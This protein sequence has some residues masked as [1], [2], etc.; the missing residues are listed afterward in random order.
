MMPFKGLIM[1][2]A[3]LV[4][5]FHSEVDLYMMFRHMYSRYWAKLN[6]F[7]SSD[8]DSIL[9]LCMQFQKLVQVW[10]PEVVFHLTRL[11]V[12]L[13]E[14]AFEWIH[15]AFAKYLRVQQLLHLWDRII[16]YDRCVF[17]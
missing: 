9:N 14:V 16:G 6:S 11:G 5:L 15:L 4:Y 7:S 13:T 17:L 1:F 10:N 8:P 2:A 12:V 3:P